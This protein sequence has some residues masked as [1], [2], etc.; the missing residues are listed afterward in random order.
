VNTRRGSLASR[1]TSA[2]SFCERPTGRPPTSTT[3]VVRS[4]SAA[5]DEA[6][7]GR[8]ARPARDGADPL[9]ELVVVERPGHVV[10]A[11]APERAH[12]VE[13]AGLGAAE[14]DHRCLAAPALELGPSPASTTSGRFARNHV[15]PVAGQ[16]PLEDAAH[17]RLSVGEEHR[18][19]HAATGSAP[20]PRPK[21]VLCRDSVTKNPQPPEQ[22]TPV[23][24]GLI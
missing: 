7:R 24:A 11:P 14:H 4:I 10:V 12:A 18:G 3:R 2:Y 8:R 17:H 1:T 15:E 21:G 23:T 20:Q 5:G 6:L 19:R 22:A 16:V 9:D 13:G